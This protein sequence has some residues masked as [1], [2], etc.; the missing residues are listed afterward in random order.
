MGNQTFSPRPGLA[1]ERT[2]FAG[3]MLVIEVNIDAGLM[4][5]V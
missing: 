1:E 4:H 5:F 2:R 3:E